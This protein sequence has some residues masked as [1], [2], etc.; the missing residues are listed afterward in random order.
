MNNLE[1]VNPFADPAVLDA[2]STQRFGSNVNTG[3]RPTCCKLPTSLIL[4]P[5][6]PV[7]VGK[8]IGA[9]QEGCTQC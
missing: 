5:L 7:D 2:A 1:D 9:R 6:H 4:T 3:M 8:T